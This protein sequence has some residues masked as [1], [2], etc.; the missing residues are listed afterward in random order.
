MWQQVKAANPGMS[1]CEVGA[2]I[3]RIWRELDGASKQRFIQD[4]SN[5]K[6]AL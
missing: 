4:F 2:A 6:V 3:G 1:V 5:D